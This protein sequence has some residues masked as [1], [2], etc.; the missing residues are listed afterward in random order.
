[1]RGLRRLQVAVAAILVLAGALITLAYRPGLVDLLD[2]PFEVAVAD[3]VSIQIDS[4]GEGP[5]GPPFERDS[6]SPG[7]LPLAL[8]EDRIPTPLPATLWQGFSC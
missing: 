5:K 7:A 6:L 2:S 4:T 8:I 3:I 1:M